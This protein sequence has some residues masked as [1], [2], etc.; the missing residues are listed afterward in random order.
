MRLL[1]VSMLWKRLPTVTMSLLND[2]EVNVKW[3]IALFK[4]WNAKKILYYAIE[5]DLNTD[6]FVY[7]ENINVV[8]SHIF[9]SDFSKVWRCYLLIKKRN[10]FRWRN[11]FSTKFVTRCFFFFFNSKSK[12]K[13]TF[14]GFSAGW[15]LGVRLQ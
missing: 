14:S 12:F 2:Y 3:F 13:W 8:N 5:T 6:C 1:R 15:H 9:I 11:S 10:C 7:L 4:Y